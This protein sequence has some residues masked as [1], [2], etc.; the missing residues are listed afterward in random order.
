MSLA[1]LPQGFCH[2]PRD[3]FQAGYQGLVLVTH[4][5]NL[6]VFL[7]AAFAQVGARPLKLRE[8]KLKVGDAFLIPLTKCA[9]CP[10]IDVAFV[11]DLLLCE[12]RHGPG[13][14]PG[15]GCS[16]R[17]LRLGPGHDCVADSRVNTDGWVDGEP[18]R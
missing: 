4:G 8:L 18:S 1:G 2:K 7:A 6:G 17:S 12:I 14:L 9:L 5:V 11:L 3:G 10:T 16:G 15:G 13:A